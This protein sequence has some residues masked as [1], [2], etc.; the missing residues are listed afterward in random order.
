MAARRWE[1][2]LREAQITVLIYNFGLVDLVVCE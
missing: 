1:V 2:D